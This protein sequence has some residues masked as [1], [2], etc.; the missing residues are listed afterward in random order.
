MEAPKGSDSGNASNDVAN[1]VKRQIEFY[2]SDSNF[3]KDKFLRA[4]SEKHP[5]GYVPISLIASFSRMKN[6]SQDVEFIASTLKDSEVVEVSE[7]GK[8]VKRKI[9]LPQEDTSSRRSI[10]AKGFPKDST[11]EDLHEFFSKVGEVLSVRMR[12]NKD[13]S[14][15]GSAFIEFKTEEDVSKAVSEK[16]AYKDNELLVLTKQEY[17]NK[18][19]E[20][21]KQREAARKTKN[22]RK[23]EE[24]ERGLIL[25]VTGVPE[26]ATKWDLKE[27]FQKHGAK[28]VDHEEGQKEARVRM[29]TPEE[30]SKAV[31]TINEEKVELKGSALTCRLLEGEE[32]EKHW[33]MINERK[34]SVQSK[35][36]QRSYS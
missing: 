23:N 8:Q 13:K 10:Y 6:L 31:Q 20:E 35:K 28:F 22:K 27:L 25:H 33:K 12:R 15:K 29:A 1:R 3:P 19:R 11:I 17:F 32:E 36:K 14:F 2:F 16:H 4:E 9:P 5:E 30:A 21:R 24:W 34:A 26:T 7:D 18:K